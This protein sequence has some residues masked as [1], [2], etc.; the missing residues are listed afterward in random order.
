MWSQ[1]VIKTCHVSLTSSLTSLF[2]SGAVAEESLQYSPDSEQSYSL[3]PPHRQEESEDESSYV[4]H[5]QHLVEVME[6]RIKQ[7][8]SHRTS[9]KLIIWKIN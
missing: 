9:F 1:D 8:G 5:T 6:E 7:V 4:S 2:R 3:T